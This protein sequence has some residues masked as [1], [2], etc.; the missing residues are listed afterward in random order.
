[1]RRHFRVYYPLYITALMVLAF[2]PSYLGSGWG[3]ILDWIIPSDPIFIALVGLGILSVMGFLVIPAAFKYGAIVIVPPMSAGLVSYLGKPVW[4][5]AN[6]DLHRY[7]WVKG[8][9]FLRRVAG[10]LRIV[11]IPRMHKLLT[12]KVTKLAAVEERTSGILTTFELR[13]AEPEEVKFVSLRD[14]VLQLV[15][16]DPITANG[17]RLKI[18]MRVFYRINDPK[19]FFLAAEDWTRIVVDRIRPIVRHAVSLDT[20]PEINRRRADLSKGIMDEIQ[21]VDHPMLRAGGEPDNRS[22]LKFMLQEYG[23]IIQA[24]EFGDMLPAKSDI[25]EA[26]EQAFEEAQRML[27]AREVAKFLRDKSAEEVAARRE[28]MRL[29]IAMKAAENVKNIIVGGPVQEIFQQVF[30]PREEPRK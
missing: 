28:A 3:E 1:M 18:S 16:S 11:G 6:T 15:F 13:F 14:Q 12:V 22:V 21:N 24:F 26:G 17:I 5:V 2:L 25:I 23:L 7:E 29:A 4:L 27:G 30:A 8:P 19:K 10:G 9:E 20:W